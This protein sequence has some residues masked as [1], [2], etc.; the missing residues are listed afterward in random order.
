MWQKLTLTT[1]A[2]T[3]KVSFKGRG[4]IYAEGTFGSG[5]V[6][7]H[8][9]YREVEG[10]A[11][12][13]STG[14]IDDAIDGSTIKSIDCP[15]GDYQLNLAGSTGATVDVYYNDQFDLVMD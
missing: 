14:F 10:G 15:A 7:L 3:A 2:N 5:A 4:S 9:V 11:E 6:G 13:I 8:V 1:A 12:T